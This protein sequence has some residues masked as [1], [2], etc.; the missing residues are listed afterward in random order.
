MSGAQTT[1]AYSV[2][3]GW[4][5]VAESFPMVVAEQFGVLESL[6]PGRID[7]GVGQ[8][9]GTGRAVARALGAGREA[10]K[11]F[12]DDLRDLYG[13]LVGQSRIENVRATPG[14]GSHVPLYLLGSSPGSAMLAASL[15][16]PYALGSQFAPTQL[17]QSVPAYREQFQPRDPGDQPHAIA[18][19]NG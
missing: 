5:D 19:I 4:G 16:L 17:Q 18:C 15:R 1:G 7:L 8:A 14:H 6:Y 11:R 12:L 2:G 10:L 13:D 9:A 3:C